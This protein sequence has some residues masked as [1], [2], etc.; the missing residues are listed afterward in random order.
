AGRHPLS[1]EQLTTIDSHQDHERTV[2]YLAK[3][4]RP[5]VVIA[6]SG[7]CSGGRVVNYLKAL[8]GD[9]RHDVLFVGYQ[10]RGT[11]GRDIQQYGPR[12]GWVAL[13]GERYDI[14]AQVHTIGGYSA[15]ADQKDL[16]NFIRRMRH[17]PR[18]VRL[19]HGDDVAKQILRAKLAALDGDIEV[20]IP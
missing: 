17:R 19:I 6:A 8:L 3:T 16:I 15:H 13:D 1:F 12:G 11:A 2:R 14:R 4:G 10:A 18:Q 7:M 5:A 20:V 9:P